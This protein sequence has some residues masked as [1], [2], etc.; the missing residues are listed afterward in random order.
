MPRY[1]FIYIIKE[2]LFLFEMKNYPMP[3]INGNILFLRVY[4]QKHLCVGFYLTSFT[5]QQVVLSI[6]FEAEF[7][8]G[9]GNV[10]LSQQADPPCQQRKIQV[11]L[12][13]TEET[14][15]Y[16][17]LFQNVSFFII[18]SSCLLKTYTICFT[19]ERRILVIKY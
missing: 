5:C 4:Y 1:S 9:A 7:V 19:V 15:C 17:T 16:L 6:C 3:P 2:M 14:G 18:Y 12:S 11:N 13:L 8:P 10:I